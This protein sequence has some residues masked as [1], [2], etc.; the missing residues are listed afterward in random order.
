VKFGNEISQNEWQFAVEVFGRNGKE[1]GCRMI[2][3]FEKLGGFTAKSFTDISQH[4]MNGVQP[5]W[6]HRHSH[7]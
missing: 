6:F 1:A 4:K 2:S 7:V 3:R 5:N